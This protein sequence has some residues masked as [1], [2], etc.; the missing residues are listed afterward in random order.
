MVFGNKGSDSGTGVAFTRDP[1]TGATGAYG[2][3]LTDAQGEDVVAGIRNTLHLDDLAKLMPQ[4]HKEL[5]QIMHTLETHYKDLCDI[6]FTVED[7]KLWML[8]TRV[9]K[10]TAAAAFRIASQLVDEGLITL[11]EA[12]QRV[13]G[14]QLTQLMFPRFDT[15][16]E[17]KLIAKGIAASPGAAVG[18]IVFSAKAAVEKAASGEKVILIRRETNLNDLA[19]MVAAAGILTAGSGKL[20]AAVVGKRYG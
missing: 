19:G 11:D 4:V 1:A 10:R 2:D 7:G 13:N 8:Q 6:E 3:W 5:M 16:A 18:K 17:K 20:H 9:G 15:K 14:V 12:L